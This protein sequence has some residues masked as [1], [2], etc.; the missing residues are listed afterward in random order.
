MGAHNIMD[1]DLRESQLTKAVSQ[2]YLDNVLFKKN[3]FSVTSCLGL[4]GMVKMIG[5]RKLLRIQ[6]LDRG[7]FEDGEYFYCF[8][9][10]GDFMIDVCPSS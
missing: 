2:C 1:A 6:G 8:H 9:N 7:N 5:V 10:G 3:V 4:S